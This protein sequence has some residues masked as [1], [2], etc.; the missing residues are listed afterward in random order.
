[1]NIFKGVYSFLGVIL[2]L[3]FTISFIYLVSQ[4]LSE[5]RGYI[6]PQEELSLIVQQG[7]FWT[8]ILGLISYAI[9]P[10]GFA[11]LIYAALLSVMTKVFDWI[12]SILFRHEILNRKRCMP[13]R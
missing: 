3:T 4:F 7:D 9:I 5:F 11:V 10:L 6:I 12:G 8:L 13:K 1:M 2:W